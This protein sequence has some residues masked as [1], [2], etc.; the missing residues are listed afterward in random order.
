MSTSSE[1]TLL[2]TTATHGIY[3]NP[4]WRYYNDPSKEVTCDHCGSYRLRSCIALSDVMLCLSC[5]DSLQGETFAEQAALNPGAGNKKRKSAQPKL[6]PGVIPRPAEND[7]GGTQTKLDYKAAA[8]KAVQEAELAA[9]V[10]A[11]G[12]TPVSRYN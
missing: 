11:I 10:F 5:T 6:A 9:P 4:A 7:T 12:M 3:F 8:R 2:K 1:E